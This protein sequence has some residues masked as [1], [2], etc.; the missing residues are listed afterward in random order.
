MI[1]RSTHS[2]KELAALLNEEPPP[3]QGDTMTQLTDKERA[4]CET[5]RN[6]DI[7]SDIY[8]GTE[9]GTPEQLAEASTWVE[10]VTDRLGTSAG[11]VVASLVKKG[12]V[13]TD[14]EVIG[15]TQAG[16]EIA[17]ALRSE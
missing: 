4:F 1:S 16:A 3:P 13:H 5:L 2:I 11:G 7:I 10:C 8:D 15:F 6:N 12:L 17:H 9:L 14:G